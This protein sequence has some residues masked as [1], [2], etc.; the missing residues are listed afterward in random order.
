VSY[1]VVEHFPKGL[2]APLKAI[3]RSLKPVGI[4]IITVPSMNKL[5]QIKYFFGKPL[6]FLSI[7]EN[8]LV[9]KLFKR[10]PLP[11]KRN[12]EGYLYYVRPQFGHFYEY[13]L[14]PNEFEDA[15]LKAG[16]AIIESIPI[17]HIDGLYHEMG[18]VFRKL[19][20]SFDNWQ[21]HVSKLAHLLNN[22]L[23]RIHFFHNHMHACVLR[24]P[25]GSAG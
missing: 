23:K 22:I 15:C 10:A 16:F 25:S 24:K 20:L 3:L 14:K 18:F 2:D 1:G 11:K 13:R 12:D 6:H 7:K 21:F 5:R 4:A 17:L 19:F 9:R 8:N